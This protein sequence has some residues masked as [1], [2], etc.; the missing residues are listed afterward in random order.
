VEAQIEQLGRGIPEVLGKNL[1]GAYLHGSAVLGG[2]RPDSDI[3]VVVVT[4]RRMAPDER[5]RLVDLLLSV[6]GKTR[7]LEVDV[8]AQSD[9]R[10]WLY[11][12]HVDFHYFE[13]HRGEFE[14]GNLEP[15]SS[16]AANHDLASVI[17]MVLA[18]D[19]ALSGPPAAEVFDP[20]P[21][22]DYVQAVLHYV[23]SVE[24]DV[25]SD[26]RNVILTLARIW[27][28]VETDEVHSKD[29]AAEWALARLP[30]EHRPVLER[31]RDLYRDGGYGPWDDIRPQVEAYVAYLVS[32]LERARRR[33]SP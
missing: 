10:P 2:L 12:P 9:I 5:Q 24:Q 26:T 33:T 17:T 18:G 32:V 21:R 31:A 8:V 4:E 28:A 30:E 11:P 6:S 23:D 13:P 27:S 16:S 25:D 7:P 3:D 29:S 19:R 20:V 14:A 15:W 22:G 1:I